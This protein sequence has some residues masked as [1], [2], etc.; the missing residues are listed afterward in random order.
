MNVTGF[1]AFD[2]SPP[3]RPYKKICMMVFLTAVG[4]SLLISGMHLL[5][6]KNNS[7]GIALVVLGILLLIPGLYHSHFAYKAYRGEYGYTFG[8]IP[9]VL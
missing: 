1:D 6:S 3:E 5:V 8:S 2:I 7:N 9:E 4:I